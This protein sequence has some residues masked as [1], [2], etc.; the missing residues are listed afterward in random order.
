M[1]RA[2]QFDVV[3]L[4]GANWDCLIKGPALPKPGET[5]T[6]MAFLSAPGGKGA[7]Q[8]VAAARLGARVALIS[9]VGKDPRGKDLR[10]RVAAEGVDLGH[11]HE[12]TEAETGAALVM[13]DALG[14]K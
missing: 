5:V 13:I 11:V 7:N 1:A 10:E 4:G 3:V 9:C 2:N 8:A 6:G 14:E 12:T